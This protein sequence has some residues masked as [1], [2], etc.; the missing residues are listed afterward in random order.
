M[1]SS[2]SYR[3]VVGI[4]YPNVYVGSNQPKRVEAS[5]EDENDQSF[6]HDPA[7]RLTPA[8][9][10]R[11]IGLPIRKEHDPDE[12]DWGEISDAWVDDEGHM[13][14]SARI[15]TDSPEGQNLYER[16]NRGD[17]YG[18]SVGYGVYAN[19]DNEVGGKFFTE[20]S[21]CEQPFF[22]G[23]AIR[24]AASARPDSTYKNN[25]PTGQIF[26]LRI[27]AS[28]NQAVLDQSNK[29]ASSLAKAHDEI[30]RKNE[31]MAARL[32]KMES[33]QKALQE[34]RA[35]LHKENQDYEKD[36]E[37]RR[38]A[39][40]EANK[41]ILKDVLDKYLE[42]YR[43]EH[44]AQAALPQDF[45]DST[46][47][48][49]AAPEAQHA[50]APIIAST[51]TWKKKKEEASA[52]A[53]KLAEMEAK[54]NQMQELHKAAEVHVEANRR[55]AL[56]SG[57][58]V[59]VKKEEEEESSHNITARKLNVQDL[60]IPKDPS[61]EEVELYQKNYGRMPI[62][63]SKKQAPPPDLPPLPKGVKELP[64][65]ARNHE[66]GRHIF[67]HLYRHLNGG[68]NGVV[69]PSIKREVNYEETKD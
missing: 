38:L 16:I 42:E 39:Y 32:A 57:D 22:K 15:W 13:R 17:I 20:I 56:F 68:L 54:L 9:V 43:E 19:E 52:H 36:A 45:V 26:H 4:A 33:E 14:C 53:T 11:F 47:N 59:V 66:A 61:K 7:V 12:G 23:A 46:T 30:L 63:A 44:G 60:W 65:S 29:D 51:K 69:I 40:A 37:A 27:M 31:E 5:M 34:E 18:L 3:I 48:A 55:K 21:V 64:N 24:V 6:Y 50:I 28:E 67:A 1:K 41:G 49:F 58:S 25:S 10:K 2:R 8:D 35:R 62:T